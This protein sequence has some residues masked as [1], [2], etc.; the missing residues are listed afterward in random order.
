[1]RNKK[2]EMEYFVMKKRIHLVVRWGF[3]LEKK[4]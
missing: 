4:I 3:Q 2:N 1:M